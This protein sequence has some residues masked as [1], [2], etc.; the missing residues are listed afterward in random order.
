[1][2]SFTYAI[3]INRAPEQVWAY[4]MD[5]D[6]APR[7]RNLVRT[8][9]P[10]TPGPLAVG[11]KL[12]V[13]IDLLGTIRTATSEIWAYE[14]ARRFGV[15]NTEQRVTGTFQYELEPDEAG[16]RVT[17]TCDVRPHGPMW[18]LLPWLLR[19]NRRR[20]REQL[21]NLKSELEQD[22]PGGSRASN[23]ARPA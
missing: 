8:I 17:F 15:R 10:V 21:P 16:T 13:T 7:W 23:A 19:G 12:K 18:L 6:K 20:Y 2:R 5:F 1:M 14:Y 22:R 3:H 4:M 11:S 9:E